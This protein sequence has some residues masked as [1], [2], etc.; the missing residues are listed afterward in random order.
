K[1]APNMAEHKPISW[2]YPFPSKD[3]SNNPLQLLTHMAQA[4]GG[5][6]PVGENGLWHGGVHF[7]ESTAAAFD[8]SSVRCIADGE[9]IAYRIDERYPVSEFTDE[10][11]RVKRAPFSTGFVL[12]K[13]RLQP[14]S[15]KNADG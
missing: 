12:V 10:I 11:P 15:L 13:H 1:D 9:V 8:Q 7:D 14:P 4:K 2:A 5:H 3:T 6:Y